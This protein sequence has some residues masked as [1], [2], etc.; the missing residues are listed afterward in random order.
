MATRQKTGSD[1][2]VDEHAGEPAVHGLVEH[3]FR[4]QAG[5]LV[6]ALARSFGSQHLQLA[7]EVVQ[8]ALIAALK[9]WPF[10][11]V[12]DHPAAWLHQVARN[13]ALDRLRRDARF[14]GKEDQIRER[15]RLA[16]EAAAGEPGQA[17]LS[18][19]ITDDQLRLVFLCCHPE[20]PRDGRVALT[21]KLVGG[22]SIDEIARAFFAKRSTIAQRLVRAQQRV[23]DRHLGLELP[24]PAELPR[25]LDAVLEAIYLIFNEGYVVH[26]GDALVRA[27]LC[28]EALRLVER[29]A[30]ITPLTRPSVHALAALLCFQASR[31][32]ARVDAEGEMLPLDEQDRALWD[33]RAIRRGFRHLELAATGDEITCY[34]LE[35]AIASQHAMASSDLDTDWPAVLALY[36]DLLHLAPSPVV[37][38]HRSVAVARVRGPLAA[39]AELDALLD[40]PLADYH[41]LHATRADLLARLGER[42]AA[43]SALQVAIA[44]APTSPERRLLE[45]RLASLGDTSTVS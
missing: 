30:A 15:I 28:G 26:R 35:A 8:E 41:L 34:H 3:L 44:R 31:L 5:R 18:G 29:L 39:L 23:R 13:R 20:L 4:H 22:F 2:L 38:L 33:R 45:R 25:R 21:L 16:A 7:E 42:Q 37:E 36:D 19:E 27:D 1:E 6:A 14:L 11:G 10:T 32:P 43:A 17:G 40:S 24:P 9:R 12:P